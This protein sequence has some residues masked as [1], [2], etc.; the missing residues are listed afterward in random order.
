MEILAS[1]KSIY[2]VSYICSYYK[3]NSLWIV[4]E[5]C[6]MGSI[7]DIIRITKIGLKEEVIGAL[8]Y[9]IIEGLYYLHN[10]KMI[11]RDIK[12]DNIL[13]TDNGQAKLADF[14]V[15]AKLL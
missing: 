4:M 8:A 2:I 7:K 9:S 1:C 15:S 13:L 5:Y 10:N 6:G 11:H 14:G 3:G 12:S